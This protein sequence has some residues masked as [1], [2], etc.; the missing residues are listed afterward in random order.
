MHMSTYLMQPFCL[1]FAPIFKWVFG[2]YMPYY[3]RLSQENMDFM[4]RHFFANPFI[5]QAAFILSDI[6]SDSGKFDLVL[7]KFIT[8]N[9]SDY[10]SHTAD[11][12]SFFSSALFSALDEAYNQNKNLV[13]LHSHRSPSHMNSNCEVDEEMMFRIIYACMPFGIHTSLRIGDD[14]LSG[15]VWLPKLTTEPLNIILPCS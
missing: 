11:S 2:V 12:L 7:N 13:F 8:L 6:V 15:K 5:M 14:E 10:E 4:Y 9:E 3:L 1:F